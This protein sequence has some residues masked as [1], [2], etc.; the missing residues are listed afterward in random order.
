MIKDVVMYRVKTNPIQDMQIKAEVRLNPHNYYLSAEAKKRLRWMYVYYYECNENAT[1]AAKKLGL[2]REWITKV[3]CKFE[4]HRKDPRSLEPGSRAPHSTENRKRI[5]KEVEGKIVEVRKEHPRWG[6]EK[7]SRIVKRDYK[8]KASPSTSNRYMKR[9][10]LINVKLS[11]KNKL[12]WEKKN[13]KLAPKVKWRPPSIIKDYKPGALVEKDVKFVLKLGTFTNPLKHRSKENFFYQH[14]ISDSFTRIRA[15]GLTNDSESKT[16]ALI[17]VKMAERL[18]FKIACMNTDN[19]S[20]N[21]KEFDE[22]L[23]NENIIHF[24]SRS[25]TPTDNPR[26]ERSHL[27]DEQEFYG[28]G[29]ICRSFEDQKAAL[30]DWEYEFNYIRPHQ[31]LGYLTPMEFYQLWKKD[32]HKAH[33]IKDKFRAYLKKQSERLAN[34]R[35]LKN[36]EQLNNLMHQIDIRLNN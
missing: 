23:S 26:V 12:A 6:K 33:A 18:P 20:E 31:A 3:K 2:T 28:L 7:I 17:Q 16:A 21:G 24:Y 8:M 9:H 10:G 19:G 32:P 22:H 14:T 1:L 15:L 11:N 5:P 13:A 34:S 4:N 29:N 35:K 25:G 27:T 36:K 30:A